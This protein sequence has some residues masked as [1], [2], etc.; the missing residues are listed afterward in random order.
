M[1]SCD[2]LVRGGHLATM[3][4]G[5]APYGAV[6]DGAL[7]VEGGRIRWVGP[8]AT[9]PAELARAPSRTLELD[10]RWVSPGLVDCHTHL[11]FGGNRAREFEARLG[12]AT[13]EEIARAGGG[14]LSTV[15]AT[16]EASEERLAE[17]AHRRLTALCSAGVTTVE[18]KSGYGLE[19][20][21]ELRML[22]VA[23]ALESSLPVTVQT[24]VLGAHTVPPEYRDD[25]TGYLDLVCREMIPEAVEEGLADAVDA[26]CEGIAFSPEE[27]GR[28]FE[29]GSAHGLPLRLHADQLSDLGGGALAARYGARSADHLEHTS[30]AS[31]R[32]MAEAGTVA[33]LLPGAF[34]FL[35]GGQRPPVRALRSYG[36]P[37]AVASDLNPGSSPVLAPLVVLNLAC[38]LFG[39]TPEEA[40]AG[41]T[42]IG[43]EALGMDHDVGTLEPGK[44]ADLAIWD[45]S[46]PAELSYWLGGNPCAGTVHRGKPTSTLLQHR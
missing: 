16:R 23:R 38:T 1:S 12:G 41:M 21:T 8:E 17:S 14:I 34:H 32:S 31:V 7:V 45:V 10:G 46:D 13:Y 6:R 28:V 5:A 39:L 37:I 33:V 15:Q 35:G 30:E 27:V 20:S 43:A 2:L 29:A 9:V 11:V 19:L 44:Q 42:R 22:R 25:R 24:T 4:P 36:V 26:F 3:E 18:I 40:L